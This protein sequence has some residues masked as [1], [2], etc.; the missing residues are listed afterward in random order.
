MKILNYDLVVFDFDK[1]LV[2][3]KI[4]WVE[5]KREIY[6]IASSHKMI[7]LEDENLSQFIKRVHGESGDKIILD[8]SER[9]EKTH[10][11]KYRIIDPLFVSRLKS[12]RFSTY[13]VIYSNNFVS[14]INE[15]LTN[16]GIY[17]AFIEIIGFDS[18]PYLKPNPKPITDLKI[19]LDINLENVLM[20]GDK[21][22][23]QITAENIGADFLHISDF[24]EKVKLV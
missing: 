17:D 8:I 5:Y 24:T 19:K 3:L 13:F 15:V 2:E 16:L 1:T 6:R 22:V 18:T 14:T 9:L 21:E 10:L 11:D 23:D 12:T 7:R 4:D 20:V